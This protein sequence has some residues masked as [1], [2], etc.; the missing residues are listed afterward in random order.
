MKF[1]LVVTTVEPNPKYEPD[2]QYSGLS[3]ELRDEWLRV[4]LTEAEW[5]RVKRAVLEEKGKSAA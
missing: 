2:R 4:T 1:E 3:P 5:E